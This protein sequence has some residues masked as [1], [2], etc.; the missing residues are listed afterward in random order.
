MTIK[1][2]S[3]KNK[4]YKFQKDIAKLILEKFNKLNPEEVVSTPS[5]INGEDLLL[6]DNAR[7]TLSNTT[8]ELKRHEKTS[9]FQWL[10]Q[11][12][13]EAE[14]LNANPI[15]IFKRNRS[16]TYATVQLDFLLEL[17]YNNMKYSELKETSKIDV[18]KLKEIFNEDFLKTVLK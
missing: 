18:D 8:F 9:I 12:E 4:G 14:R 10:E 5:S 1:R 13:L 7:K 16:K 15:L 17:L 11:N 6:S 3:A 2:R